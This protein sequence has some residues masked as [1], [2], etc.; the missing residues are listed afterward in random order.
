MP[1]EKIEPGAPESQSADLAADNLAQ[2]RALFPELV[3]EGKTGPAINVDVLKAL[4]GDATVTDADEKYGLNWHGK[5]A[6]RQLALTPSTG[7]LRPC[8][9]DSVDWDTT[10][11]LMIE[12]DNLEVLKL[13]QKSYAGKVKLIYIDPP[14]NTGKD[15]VYPDDFKDNIKNYLELT[16]QVEG[17]R[18]ISSNTEASGRFHTDWLNMMYPRLRLARQ[19]LRDDGI[20]FVSI[21]DGE[22]ENARRLLNEIYGEENFI[23]NFIWKRKAGGGD[24]SGHVAAEHEYVICFAKDSAAAGIA[25][26]QHESPAMTAKYNRSEGGRRYY[27]ERLDK[28]S[29]TYNSSMDFPIECPD[30]TFI[31][32]PQPNPANPTTSWRWGK[33]TVQTRAAELI[34]QKDKTDQW[35][36]YT[37]TWEPKD[38]VTPR[39]LMVEKEYGRNRDGTQ[40][41]D[42]LLGPKIFNNP[43]PT[44][45]LSHLLNIG[46]AEKD[47]VVLDFFAGSG[48]LA[49]A[50]I[51]MNS[52]DQGC[53]RFILVQLPEPTDRL[54][55][56]KISSITRERIL[57]AGAKAKAENPLFSGDVGFRVFKL[58]KSNIAAWAPKRDDL[59]KSLLD[60]LEHVVTGRSDDDVLYEMLIKLGL[61]LCVPIE[62]KLI[63]GKTVQSIGG[64]VL[65]ACLD[66]QITVADAEPLALGIVAW[67]REQQT[68]GEVTCVFRD[69]AFENDVAKTNLAAI[70]EQH[71]IAKVRSL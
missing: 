52:R 12:G 15:F 56:T 64:G 9:E 11:N 23:A 68:A 44:K 38:G 10:Q 39:T 71:G 47:A 51:R 14:Y 25:S 17:G 13:L 41:L 2:L 34:F 40:E 43:K 49:D 45:F 21:D 36:V 20:I 53:R 7:T 63:A 18:K 65:L 28:T 37:R 16:C 61:N 55:F 59:A 62:P 42:A 33:E 22:F 69:S 4:V 50:L 29:L 30:G 32:P 54:D 8:P 3:T 27:L 6:A 58:D 35:R 48:S 57:R 24:D 19:L 31:R 70:L 1:I 5:R 46:A 26:V 67:H 60:H 66:E